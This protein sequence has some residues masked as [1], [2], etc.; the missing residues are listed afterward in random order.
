MARISK[1]NALK[2]KAKPKTSKS[3]TTSVETRVA[4][5]GIKLVEPL[6]AESSTDASLSVKPDSSDAKTAGDKKVS[7]KL[8]ET[9]ERRKKAQGAN[10]R[11]GSMFGKA[12]GRRGRR[13]KA[14][15][16]YV[17]GNQEEEAGYVLENDYEGLEYDTGIRVKEGG[18][19]KG[20]NLDRFDDYDEELN[21][22]W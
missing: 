14:A 4:K 1:S 2:S 9:I 16:E 10:G 8:L 13:P 20:F 11:P 6:V 18:D 15:M 7:Q 22:D 19:D 5:R 17:P 12:P 3:A 21:F